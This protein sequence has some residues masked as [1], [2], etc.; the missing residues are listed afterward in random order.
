[1]SPGRTKTGSYDNLPRCKCGGPVLFC[2]HETPDHWIKHYKA[3]FKCL[4]C[5]LLFSENLDRP[6]RILQ[7]HTK[8]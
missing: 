8:D 1:M 4:A 2:G 7:D 5:G 6:L 3:W